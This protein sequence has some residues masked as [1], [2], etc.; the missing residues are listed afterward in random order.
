MAQSRRKGIP[1]YRRVR[2][3]SM[4]NRVVENAIN[5][6]WLAVA[7]FTILVTSGGGWMSYVQ[8]Q[9]NALTQTAADD[10]KQGNSEA[11]NNAITREKVS[12]IE[13][14]VDSVDRKVQDLQGDIKEI[15]RNQQEQ[16][17]R[18]RGNGSG[19]PPGSGIR[20]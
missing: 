9:I 20:R 14:K 8:S 1:R 18:Q 13:K 19:P 10:R 12:N 3:A 5:W 7:A 4:A 15:L 11:T 17:Y 6:K 2:S 16:I